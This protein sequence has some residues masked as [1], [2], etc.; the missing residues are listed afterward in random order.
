MPSQP[1]LAMGV[2]VDGGSPI[3][4][5]N[6][7]VIEV[8]GIDEVHFNAARAQELAEI[9]RRRQSCLGDHPQLEIAGRV[10]IVVD[11]GIAMGA[12][13][14]A[15]LQ[16]VA[17]AEAIA[18]LRREVDDVASLEVHERFRVIG[19]YYDDFRQVSDDEV[20]LLLSQYPAGAEPPAAP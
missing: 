11:D 10:A 18:A 3:V 9:G 4:V 6:E 1:E 5:R 17:P 12:T 20:L 16:P 7:E 19:L 8:V 2:I 14:R 15:A 13:M